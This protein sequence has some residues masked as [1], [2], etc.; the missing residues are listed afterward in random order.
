[1]IDFSG[2]NIFVPMTEMSYLNE[3]R[4][5]FKNASESGVSKLRVSETIMGSRAQLGTDFVLSC[6]L[7]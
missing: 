3:E 2:R 1:M 4:R 5:I 7:C 6:L